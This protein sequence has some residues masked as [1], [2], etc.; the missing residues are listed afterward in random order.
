M[1]EKFEAVDSQ[2]LRITTI[3]TSIVNK[4][5]L[6]REKTGLESEIIILQGRLDAVNSK[7]KFLLNGV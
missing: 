1:D 6:L 4:E 3:K 2:N 5:C 7:L